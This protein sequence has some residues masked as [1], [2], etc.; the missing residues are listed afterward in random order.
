MSNVTNKSIFG[1][2]VGMAL[3]LLLVSISSCFGSS[4]EKLQLGGHVLCVPKKHV[5]LSGG[6]SINSEQGSYDV[7]GPQLVVSWEPE[8]VV[9]NLASYQLRHGDNLEYKSNLKVSIFVPSAEQ[10]SFWK[11]A[12]PY[13]DRLKLTGTFEDAVVSQVEAGMYKVSRRSESNYKW[14]VLTVEPGNSTVIPDKKEDFWLASCSSFGDGSGVNCYTEFDYS[15]LYFRVA[16]ASPNLH[17]HNEIKDFIVN[18]LVSW[19]KCNT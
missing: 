11:S 18:Q 16:I 7:G 12:T 2:L 17:L 19:A 6:D 8:D 15:G 14:E 5:V 4:E 3:L 1:C 13:V 9:Q 10:L